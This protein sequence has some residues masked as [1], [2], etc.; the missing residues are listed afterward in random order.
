VITVGISAFYHDSACAVAVDGRIVAAAQEERFTRVRYDPD[1]PMYAF[2]SCLRQAGITPSGIDCVAYYENPTKKLSRQLWMHLPTAGEAPALPSLDATFPERQIRERLGY[3]G[4]IETVDHHEAHAATAFYCSGYPE[5]ALFTADAVGEWTTTSYGIGGEDGVRIVEEVPFPHSLGLLYSTIT[6]YLGFS[7]N[8]DEYKVMGLAAYGRPRHRAALEHL[9]SSG[10]DG[11]FSLDMRYFSLRAA[12]RM[13]TRA[14]VDLLDVPP[15]PPG[16]EI[17]RGHEDLASSVQSLLEDLLLDKLNYLHERCG[18]DNLC[19]AGGV[20]LNCVANTRLRRRGK[21]RSWFVPPSPGDSGSAIG[22]ALLAQHRMTGTRRIARMT[23]A[24]LGPSTLLVPLAEVL[25]HA[26][27]D[28][29][30]YTGREPELL[31]RVARLLAGGAV[32]GWYQGRMEFGP[33]ALGSRSILADPRP[34]GL[35]DR[36][37]ELV[38]KREEFRPFAPAVPVEHAATFFDLDVPSPFMLEAVAVR[39]GAG[40]AAVTHVDG[41]A[42]VQTVDRGDDGRFH[43]LLTRFGELTGVPVLLNTSFNERGEPIVCGEMDALACFVRA[44]MDV[45]VVGDLVLHRTAVPVAWAGH[46]SGADTNS[47]RPV[48]NDSYTF[49]V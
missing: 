35:R 18:S 14:L 31:D 10:V 5:A 48:H 28:Y 45:L 16:A 6:S 27:V 11:Q 25:R 26:G 33:R 24:R 36:I 3:D 46:L 41:S 20:A 21:F 30:D 38:K 19:Y 15:R 23:D 8:S 22:A 12:G 1:I 13:F 47:R 32:V 39:P 17:T 37:N 2:R 29:E 42:R 40:L 9:V 49:F 43:A 7:V 4:P 44:G 34:A